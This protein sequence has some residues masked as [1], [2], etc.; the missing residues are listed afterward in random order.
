MII[1]SYRPGYD[2]DFG[3]IDN[4][5]ALRLGPLDQPEME[6]LI[7]AVTGAATAPSDLGALIFEHTDGNPLFAEE[8]CFSLLEAKAISVRDQDVILN[9]PS[10]QLRLPDTVQAVIRARLDRLDP[11]A[12]EIVGPASVIG[13]SFTQRVL[14]RI[15]R[16]PTPLEKALD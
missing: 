5:T 15:C 2:F 4:R 10:S 14:A 9:Q 11:G 13:R 8:I 7:E 6:R 3:Q 16:G 12:K 1:V